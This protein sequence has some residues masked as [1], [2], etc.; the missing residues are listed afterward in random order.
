ML[1]NRSSTPSLLFQFTAPCVFSVRYNTLNFDKSRLNI[2]VQ[3]PFHIPVMNA[4]TGVREMGLM[5]AS[6]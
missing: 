5:A 4:S 2:Q 3:T 6:S 1:M